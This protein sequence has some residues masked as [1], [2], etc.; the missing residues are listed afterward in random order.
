YTPIETTEWGG[1]LWIADYGPV[2][3]SSVD[4]F[5]N[6]LANGAGRYFQDKSQPFTNV[7]ISRD[8]VY[9]KNRGFKGSIQ[10][11]GYSFYTISSSL[12][13]I[14][15]AYEFL[16]VNETGIDYEIRSAMKVYNPLTGRL[17]KWLAPVPC[18]LITTYRDRI[19]VAGN[20]PHVFYMSR[21]GNPNDWNFGADPNDPGRAVGGTTGEA[22]K[23]GKP[24]TALASFTDDFLVIGCK[25]ELWVVYGDMTAGGAMLNVSSNVGIVGPRAWCRTPEG[26][27]VFMS[28]NGLYLLEPGGGSRPRKLSDRIPQE[29]RSYAIYEEFTPTLAWDNTG[30]SPSSYGVHI[31]LGPSNWENKNWY[32]DFKND[33]FWEVLYQDALK[34]PFAVCQHSLANPQAPGLSLAMAGRDGL[35]RFFSD[36]VS[37]DDESPYPSHVL[38]GPFKEG[39]TLFDSL[40]DKLVAVMGEMSGPV[41]WSIF[42][43]PNAESAYEKYRAGTPTRTGSWGPGRNKIDIPRVRGVAHYLLIQAPPE[44]IQGWEMDEIIGTFQALD[45]YRPL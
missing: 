9:I 19:V 34:Y 29:L 28:H 16:P 26:A 3:A 33:A 23:I 8:V 36:S 27:M 6:D 2:K 13:R 38:L 39:A 21:A 24:I 44:S 5:V 25:N 45:V 14:G 41:N 22:G 31:L 30:A 42:S 37:T 18:P 10:P 35:I 12:N 20:P 4:G 17:E 11:G 32:Y 7:D 40:L 15:L 1:R 43:G